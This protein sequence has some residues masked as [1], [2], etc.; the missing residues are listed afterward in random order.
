MF[1]DMEKKEV[2]HIHDRWEKATGML[3]KLKDGRII[4]EYRSDPN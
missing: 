1:V 2:V 3:P 4:V